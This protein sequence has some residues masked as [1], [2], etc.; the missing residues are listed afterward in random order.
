MSISDGTGEVTYPNE[1]EILAN[2][3]GEL[4]ATAANAASPVMV[5]T[6]DHGVVQNLAVANAQCRNTSQRPGHRD[7]GRLPG[8]H[9][10]R[11][12]RAELQRDRS[13][14]RLRY[15]S[16]TKAGKFAE[17]AGFSEVFKRPAYQDEVAG[18]TRSPMR[19]VPDITADATEGTSEATPMIAGILA[20]ATQRNGGHDLGPVN[21]ALY[22]IGP[23]GAWPASPM[24]STAATPHGQQAGPDRRPGLHRRPGLRRS[25]P[26]ALGTLF[27]PKFVPALVEA[28]TLGGEAG[29]KA[30]AAASWWS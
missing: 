5:A 20:L 22:K 29:I 3:P 8:G 14:A 6:G 9:R 17:G 15:G 16:G 26:P 21:P 18:I 7:L 23:A 1:S 28:R 30:Q 11:R 4:T 13:A 25:W 12:Q 19:S 2:N 10:R 27:A 24:S